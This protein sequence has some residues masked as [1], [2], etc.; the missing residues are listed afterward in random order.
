[1]S[2][3]SFRNCLI[4]TILVHGS[5][6]LTD[7]DYIGPRDK[8]VKRMDNLRITQCLETANLNKDT[9]SE[10]VHQMR[11][12]CIQFFEDNIK[13]DDCLIVVSKGKSDQE[14]FDLALTCIES[15]TSPPFDDNC[16]RFINLFSSA[17]S[18]DLLIEACLINHAL[19]MEEQTCKDLARTA[20]QETESY[21][22]WLSKPNVENNLKICAEANVARQSGEDD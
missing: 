14:H 18:K 2:L 21:L 4:V 10:P 1:M 5:L 8:K 22:P 20:N 3:V 9:E 16:K 15:L 13:V 6:G 7:F 17:D 12:N 19:T 11:R